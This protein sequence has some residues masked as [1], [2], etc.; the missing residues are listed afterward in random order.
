MTIW[1][2]N[3]K[4]TRAQEVGGG[5]LWS[6]RT[7]SDGTRNPTYENM[8]RARPG[9]LV[10]SYA[11]TRIGAIGVVVGEAVAC[12]KPTE[13]ASSTEWADEGWLVEVRFRELAQPIVP[14]E[15]M[16]TLAPLLPQKYS[17]L[18]ASGRGNQKFYLVEVPPALADELLRVA[19]AVEDAESIADLRRQAEQDRQADEAERHLHDDRTLPET[20]KRQ[21]VLARRGQG[22]YR[23]RLERLERACRVT[24][25]AARE[26]LRASHI[27][28][29]RAASNE[30][31]LDG[32]NGLLLAP[33]VDHL[34]DRGY[35]S[36][37][38]DGTML[39]S[40]ALDPGVLDC[41][42][43]ARATRVERFRDAQKRYLDYHRSEV[44]RR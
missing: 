33:H 36:F 31:R 7:N 42:G 6:P 38:D 17:P 10:F 37:A 1:W 32:H 28:P 12:P 25:I 20:E 41:W 4:R 19:Q 8:T 5:Y 9:D 18:Q 16:A 14:K 26:H 11:S 24:G 21:L 22:L 29:W 43:I 35:V 39:V 3:H 40:A 13:F 23:S 34:F 15:L 2:V 27:K 44:F 30:E